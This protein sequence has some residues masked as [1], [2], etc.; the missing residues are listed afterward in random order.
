MYSLRYSRLKSNVEKDAYFNTRSSH[1]WIVFVF[2][3]TNLVWCSVYPRPQY[4]P[5][6]LSI[7]F[8]YFDYSGDRSLSAETRH[9]QRVSPTLT[10]HEQ[11]LDCMTPPQFLPALPASTHNGFVL[12]TKCGC[13]SWQGF[14]RRDTGGGL[15]IMNQQSSQD[16]L[17]DLDFG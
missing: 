17:V 13:R 9:T 2:K 1:L 10:A 5:K 7:S 6:R 16:T 15:R 8:S 11:L 12:D 4:L 3:T 14:V